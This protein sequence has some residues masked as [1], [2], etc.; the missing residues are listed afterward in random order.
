MLAMGC[1][2]EFIKEN[3]N[4][5]LRVIIRHAYVGSMVFW[6]T[7]CVGHLR[8]GRELTVLGP[9]DTAKPS[10]GGRGPRLGHPARGGGTGLPKVLRGGGR[11]SES[12]TWRYWREE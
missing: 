10:D 6:K 2:F 4:T 11:A 1:N 3:F 5:K 12:D 8:R 7:R 9:R